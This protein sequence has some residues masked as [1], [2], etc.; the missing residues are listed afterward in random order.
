MSSDPSRTT[1]GDSDRDSG[2]TRGTV[3][4]LVADTGNRTAIR[5]MLSDYFEVESGRTVQ[6]A[7]LY[8]IEDHLFAEH[9][10][11]LREQV[12]EA[13][14]AFCPVVL[15]RRQTTD[16]AHPAENTAFHEGPML[17][18]DVVDA[19]LDRSLLIRRLHSLLV[20]RRQSQEL[21]G[22]VSTLE[23]REQELRRFER[24]VESTGNGLVM[25]DRR[26]AIEYVN[27]AFEEITGYTESEVL[28][29]TPRLLQPVGA[30]DVFS[31]EFWR[32]LVDR[33]QWAGEVVIEHRDETR[34]VVDM[35]IRAIHDDHGDVEGFVVVLNDITERIQ[36]EQE[37]ERREEELDLLRQII[38]RY[39][40]HNL[41]NDLNVILGYGEML[42]SDETLSERQVQMAAKMVEMAERLLEK[43]DTAR[44]YSRLLEQDSEL[45]PNDL[46]AVVNRSVQKVS[47]QYP[48]VVFDVDVPESCTIR[49]R[50]GIQD[51]IEELILN[52]TKHNDATSPHVHIQLRDSKGARLVIEDNGSG[53]SEFELETLERG[54]ETPLLHSQGI[55]LW[56]SKWVIESVDGQL[57]FDRLDSGT[58]VT[59][60]FPAPERVGSSGLDAPTLKERDER[61]QTVIDRM[62]DAIVEVNNAWEISF[63]DPRAADILGV[64]VDEVVGQS[65]WE[66][67][68]DARDTQFETVY[69]D[70]MSSRTS[71]H[72]EAY[73]AGIDGWLSVYVYPEFDGGLS[74]YFRE[75]TERNRREQQLERTYE[76][77]EHTERIANVGSWEINTDTMDVYWSEN[78]FELLGVEGDEEPPLDEALDVYHEDDRPFV[79][80]AVQEAL[81]TGVPFDVEPRFRRPDGE[82]RWLRVQGTPTLEDGEVVTLRGAIQDITEYKQIEA[83]L[84]NQR[85]LVEGIVETSPI[86]ITVVDAD[87]TISFVNDRA[88]E[89]Y[90]RSREE[91]DGV[92]HDDSRWGLVDGEGN[93][94]EADDTPFGRVRAQEEPIYEQIVGLRRPSGER[95]WVSVNGAPQWDDDGT[96]QRAIFAFEDITDRRAQETQLRQAHRQLANAVEAGAIGI[97]EWDVQENRVVGGREFANTFSVDPEHAEQGIELDLFVSKIHEDDRERVGEQVEKA[98]SACGDYEAEYRVWTAD[99]EYRWVLA[100]G[101]VE[102]EADGTPVTVSGVLVDITDRK[103]IERELQRHNERLNEF[104]GVVSHDLQKPLNIV[105]SRLERA[106]EEC[107]SEHLDAIEPA[108][109]RM[110]RIIDDLLWLAR[111]QQDVGSLQTVVVQDIVGDAWEIVADSSSHATVHYAD[112]ALAE[113][114]VGADPDRLAQLFENLLGNAIEH[115]GEDVSVTVGALED[116]FYVEDDGPGIPEGERGRVFTA[117]YSTREDGTGFGLR[118]VEQIVDAHGWELS[119]TESADGGARFEVTGVAGADS[120]PAGE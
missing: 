34:S 70:V 82:I 11:A 96:L 43:S 52:A 58:R 83:E 49:S 20:R 62:T 31:E 48:D 41:R 102:C 3:Q 1:A 30:A 53:I 36:Y 32:T 120:S 13:H 80:A 25:T 100:R 54:K 7:D 114:T 59:V 112:D 8:L 50:A 90:G 117:G 33:Q 12:E 119:V 28:E 78:L 105:K 61:L 46:S 56:L 55:G 22:H 111:N 108:V 72:V 47:K 21:S 16:L 45:S 93:R 101:H 40:R 5:K 87:G 107:E 23:E 88:E 77:L 64:S 81:E 44:Q 106:Q 65:L 116:G 75:T 109:E 73:Y 14:P 15:I 113:T 66:V 27:P 68:S 104:A 26:G 24:G 98:L 9:Q 110:H 94:L 67:F 29:E 86:G 91:V 69:R 63:L 71:Q 42:V 4:L 79:E 18:D 57:S 35:S 38:T 99:N 74:F 95:V 17:I 118:I 76:L 115:G 39:L 92:A 2:D 19:P 10:D 51:A 103:E 97:W 6:D 60:E 84:R 37:L 85:N 89:L